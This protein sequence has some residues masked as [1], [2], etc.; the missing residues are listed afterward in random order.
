MRPTI[1]NY[2]DPSNGMSDIEVAIEE[3]SIATSSGGQS[4]STHITRLLIPTSFL[5]NL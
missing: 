4:C 1:V 2:N 3:P 5:Y